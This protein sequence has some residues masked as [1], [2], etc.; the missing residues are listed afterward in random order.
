MAIER[1]RS[2]QH[3]I[4]VL[5]RRAQRRDQRRRR[6]DDDHGHRQGEPD[7]DRQPPAQAAAGRAPRR[8]GGSQAGQVDRIG[9]ANDGHRVSSALAYRKVIR[10]S[11][12]AYIRSTTRLTTMM[13]MVNTVMA[14]WA[15]G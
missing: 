3:R 13:I 12:T 6:G 4:G 14:P 2:L 9:S 10:G 5:G 15:S 8:L 7:A 11:T 1:P